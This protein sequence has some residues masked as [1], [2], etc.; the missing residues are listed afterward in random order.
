VVTRLSSTRL[1]EALPNPACAG[2]PPAGSVPL[3][4]YSPTNGATGGSTFRLAT[5]TFIFNWDTSSG[6]AKGCY[7]IVVS[8]DDGTQKATIVKLQ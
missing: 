1:L 7:N 6:V 3:V 8:L 5:D 4:L 2:A